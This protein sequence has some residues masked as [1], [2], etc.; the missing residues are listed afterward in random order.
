MNNLSAVSWF[1]QQV[2]PSLGYTWNH[3]QAILVPNAP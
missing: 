1:L 3:K 2:L